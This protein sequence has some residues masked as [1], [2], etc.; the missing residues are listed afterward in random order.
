MGGRHDDQIGELQAF[1]HREEHRL[2]G[3][4]AQLSQ[5]GAA[6]V[7]QG[8]VIDAVAGKDTQ[9]WTG[10]VLAGLV[11]YGE[12][13]VAQHL[14]QPVS[15]RR[16]HVHIARNLASGRSARMDGHL[17]QDVEHTVGALRSGDLHNVGS[18]S[19]MWMCDS[20]HRLI[21]RERQ[22]PPGGSPDSL[23]QALLGGFAPGGCVFDTPISD[24]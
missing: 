23:N 13:P 20:D 11:L 19:I 8:G 15:S 14:E 16:G 3:L 21:R 1:S 2:R 18:I 5:Q 10:H 17:G 9:L 24:V 6:D 4:V 7:V 12:A 22:H